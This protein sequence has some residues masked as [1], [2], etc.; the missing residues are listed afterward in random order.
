MT[1]LS[2]ALADV[3][4]A[5]RARRIRFALVGGLA[6]SARAEPRFTNDVDLCVA[7]EGDREAEALVRSL[8]QDGWEVLAQLEQEETERLAT[9][10]LRPPGG[11]GPIVD[12]LFASSGIEPAI[13]RSAEPMSVRSVVRVPVARIGHLV[14]MKVL[15]RDDRTR[16]QDRVDLVRLV[17]VATAR[18]LAMARRALA[19]IV[20][21]GFGRGRDLVADLDA[22]LQE[23]R[24]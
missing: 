8:L 17:D 3:V 15:A 9:V 5:L 20:A 7:V 6:V 12:L 18:D 19:R 14:A 2:A 21:L 13:V 23:L 22:L 4:T 11:S 1:A 10:R 24:G 16:P